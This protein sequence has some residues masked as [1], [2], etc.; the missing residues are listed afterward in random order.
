MERYQL[1]LAYDG[2]DFLGSQRQGPKRTVQ[3][4]VEAALRGIGWQGS[5]ILLAGRTDTGVHA[6]G[7]V[8]AFDLEWKHSGEELKSALNANLPPDIAV[9]KTVKTRRD[10]H[11]R[12]DALA[13]CYRYS[14]FSQPERNP[15]LERFSWRLDGQPSIE[16]LCTAA[17][18]LIG[19]HD[20][21]NFGRAMH[22]ENT[23]VRTVFSTKW[24]AGAGSSLAFEVIADAF[25][26]HM[27]RRMVYLQMLVGLK[28]LSLDEFTRVLTDQRKAPPG[29]APAAGL[30]L[31]ECFYEANWQ[32]K[33]D[34]GIA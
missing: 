13:R 12:F 20:F 24:Y 21:K 19:T 28:S 9:W 5:A 31:K 7:Q 33:Y 6:S 27:V 10:F 17:S 14:T 25:L 15:L 2:T 22:P 23:S 3:G 4:E 29:M 8:A 32:E 1:I 16:L 18:R 34:K 11:P 26:Y 30:E